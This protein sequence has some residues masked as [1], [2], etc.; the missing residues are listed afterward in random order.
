MRA[1]ALAPP[2]ATVLRG[3]EPVV[4]DLADVA[5]GDSI[6]VRPGDRVPL[7]AT[8]TRGSSSVDQ[9][10]LTGESLPVD[11][12]VG[13]E[14]FAGTINGTGRLVDG[15]DAARDTTVNNMGTIIADRV[16]DR[17][18]ETYTLTLNFDDYPEETSWEIT[19]AQGVVATSNGRP[20]SR[21]RR[22]SSIYPGSVCGRGRG[23]P[24]RRPQLAAPIAGRKAGA[25]RRGPPPCQDRSTGPAGTETRHASDC[26]LSG[27]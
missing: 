20:S 12:Q 24:R 18:T 26:S 9:A 25:R 23:A 14:I 17:C 19:N 7:D 1:D 16:L 15:W 5:L 21:W 22:I 3:A 6:L 27:P 2:Q 11:K 10:W 8:V 4:I 13:D